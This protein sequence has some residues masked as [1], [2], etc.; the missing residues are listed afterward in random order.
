MRP[1]A[2]R[3]P[4]PLRAVRRQLLLRRR[5]I[6]ATLAAAAVLA[7]LR[8]SAPPPESTALVPVAAHDLPAGAR[9]AETDVTVAALPTDLVPADAA[10]DPVGRVLA[11]PVAGGEPLTGLRLVGPAFAEA[12]PGRVVLPVRLPDAGMAALLRP[13]DEV[14]LVSTDPG[15]G[16]SELVASGVRVLAAPRDVPDGPTGDGGGAL[17]VVSV[18]PGDQLDVTSAALT[19]F[20]TVAY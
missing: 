3:L 18:Q 16:E 8:V 13:G 17:V 5:L 9:L 19:K 12:Q 10:A 7:A 11:G 4:P 6:A 14:D 1:I 15:T 20:L 2:T